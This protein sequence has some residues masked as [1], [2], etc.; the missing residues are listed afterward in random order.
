M[1]P[2][3]KNTK[4]CCAG[5]RRNGSKQIYEHAHHGQPGDQMTKPRGIS[6]EQ[7]GGHERRGKPAEPKKNIQKIQCRRAMSRVNIAAQSIGRS[8]N[9]SAAGAEQKHTRSDAAKTAGSRQKR[10]RERAEGQAQN[11]SDFLAFV[12]DQRTHADGGQNQAQR[13]AKRDGAILFR[14]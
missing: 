5:H 9:Y 14:S 11:Q 2:R 6:A 4:V 13:L 1:L 10:H 12:I 8:N 7:I 3:S